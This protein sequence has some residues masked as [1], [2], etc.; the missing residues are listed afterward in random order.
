MAI[1]TMGLDYSWLVN[2]AEMISQNRQQPSGAQATPK[3]AQGVAA[4]EKT[5]YQLDKEQRREDLLSRQTREHE[6]LLK[7]MEV[8]SKLAEAISKE[9]IAGMGAEAGTEQTQIAGAAQVAAS[10]KT[11]MEKGYELMDM[12]WS[13]DKPSRDEFVSRLEAK[14]T[15]NQAAQTDRPASTISSGGTTIPITSA[16][17]ET[18]GDP[19][20]P[21]TALE[22]IG[23][24]NSETG[25]SEPKPTGAAAKPEIDQ[26]ME[27]LDDMLTKN[28]QSMIAI[29][30]GEG[31]DELKE[32]M[33]TIGEEAGFGEDIIDSGIAMFEAL[34][35]E[36][37]G[38]P[39]P[40]PLSKSW[41]GVKTTAANVAPFIH[42][43]LHPEE[44][45]TEEEK[46]AEQWKSGAGRVGEA[47]EF[48]KS[49]AEF[50][51]RIVTGPFYP[52]YE[53]SVS[54]KTNKPVVEK[55][56][57]KEAGG[58]TEQ[59]LI[60]EM[61]TWDKEK[62]KAFQIVAK[63]AGLYKGEINGLHSNELN[64]AMKEYYKGHKEEWE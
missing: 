53:K 47:S 45:T 63:K 59:D 24:Y 1:Q 27:L 37:E 56:T 20:D 51:E 8:D 35:P 22:E 36:P 55:P 31:W 6:I 23:V 49:L 16:P 34:I 15:E 9:R 10:Q 43:A 50:M 44:K 29:T 12:L 58:I 60:T 2:L 33:R 18:V 13:M 48:G 19:N 25:L 42:E 38:E 11:T 30:T 62:V 54:K 17:R 64:N 14:R 28:P 7:Q 5:Q 26:Y 39:E 21:L 52:A 40:S 57:P 46:L 4:P 32:T 3:P 61:G 41:G